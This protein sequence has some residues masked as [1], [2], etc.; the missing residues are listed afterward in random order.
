MGD[1]LS[2]SSWVPDLHELPINVETW[3]M[4]D[5]GYNNKDFDDDDIHYEI[6]SKVDWYITQLELYYYEEYKYEEYKYELN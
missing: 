5:L 6:E 3:N 1:W 4:S 2:T